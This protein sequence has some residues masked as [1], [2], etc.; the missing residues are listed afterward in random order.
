MDGMSNEM[1]KD[2]WYSLKVVIGVILLAQKLL[3]VGKP[4][5]DIRSSCCD[6]RLDAGDHFLLELQ[7]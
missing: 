6:F 3:F 2:L 5:R 4:V 7:A 1:K